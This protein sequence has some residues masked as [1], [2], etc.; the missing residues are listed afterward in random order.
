MENECSCCT[1]YTTAVNTASFS[2]SKSVFGDKEDKLERIHLCLVNTTWQRLRLHTW[3]HNDKE[4]VV[5]S[6]LSS[7]RT[8]QSERMTL[9]V[10]SYFIISACLCSL[11]ISHFRRNCCG[12]VG[13][14]DD[15]MQVC[16]D[17]CLSRNFTLY[18]IHVSSQ[19]SAE[20]DRVFWWSQCVSYIL[21]FLC[22][23]LY[24]CVILYNI[25]K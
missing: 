3:G 20:I 8:E 9:H 2:D 13:C 7:W 22:F 16:C 24:I 25:G 21:V 17:E 6:C 23:N 15:V 18:F 1:F 14:G 5:K 11:V 19:C 4:A 12:G 10:T